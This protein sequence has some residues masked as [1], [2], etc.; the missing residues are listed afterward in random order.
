MLQKICISFFVSCSL[1]SCGDGPEITV[2]LLAPLR[3][4]GDCHGPDGEVEKPISEMDK[5][6][7]MSDD[8][9]RAVYE[10][11]RIARD[12]DKKD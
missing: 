1:L 7:A 8:D 10:Y 3:A 4:V 11:C 12:D 5:W 6:V 2:C 9:A